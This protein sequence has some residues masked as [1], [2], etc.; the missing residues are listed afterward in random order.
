V[1]SVG[2][3]FRN[4]FAFFGTRSTREERVVAYVIREHHRG[5]PLAE[6]LDDPYVRNRCTPAERNR[7]L[8]RPEVIHAI[9]EDIVNAVRADMAQ[10]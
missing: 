5:R 8:D 4:L 6:I 9:G 3:F 10:S 7:L 2:D 1:G